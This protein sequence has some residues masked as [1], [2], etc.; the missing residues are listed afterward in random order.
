MSA[1][2]VAIVERTLLLAGAL[3]I[4][5]GIGAFDWRLGLLVFGGI[6]VAS[7]LD[8]RRPRR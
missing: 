4:I 2:R 3:A 8:I 1:R 6:A 7:T 5:L